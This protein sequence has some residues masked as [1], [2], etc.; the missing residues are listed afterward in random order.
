MPV[1]AARWIA[2]MVCRSNVADSRRPRRALT[3]DV[4]V[5]IGG[6]SVGRSIV[7]VEVIE[8][9]SGAVPRVGAGVLIRVACRLQQDGK[10]FVV[11]GPHL[12]GHAV[13]AERRGAAAQVDS[14]LVDGVPERI[15]GVAADDQTP[16]L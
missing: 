4:S 12:L 6:P 7:D 16:G 10:F 15:A 14:R 3:S 1:S 8:A 11:L 2:A 13:C 5:D 9:A